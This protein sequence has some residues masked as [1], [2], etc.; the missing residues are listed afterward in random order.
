[1]PSL[2]SAKLL[3]DHLGD[4]RGKNLSTHLVHV[5]S[6]STRFDRAMSAALTIVA[7]HLGHSIDNILIPL[8]VLDSRPT[9]IGEAL[10]EYAPR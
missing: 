6:W 9:G 5:G 7:G 10:P 2:H 8:V 4:L 1:M 3:G